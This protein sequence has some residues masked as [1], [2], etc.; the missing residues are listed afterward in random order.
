MSD[1]EVTIKLPEQLIERARAVGLTMEDQVETFADAVEKEIRRREAGK[2]LRES[3][4]SQ[5]AAMAADLDIQ[6]EISLIE[7]E[8]AGIDTNT[9][10]Q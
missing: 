6:R 3:D 10:K 1:V 9:L 2:R 5:L 4:E 7:A 8:F